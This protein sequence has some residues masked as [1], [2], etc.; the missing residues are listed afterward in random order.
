MRQDGKASTN[1]RYKC[2]KAG[3]QAPIIDTNASRREGYKHPFR[4]CS[5]DTLIAS[6]TS[7]WLQRYASLPV[8]PHRAVRY[9]TSQTTWPCHH[10]TVPQS[11]QSH[12]QCFDMASSGILAGKQQR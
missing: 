4:L 6:F 1:K 11:T 10:F 5:K 8:L 3:K 9:A 12:S 7:T 2:I